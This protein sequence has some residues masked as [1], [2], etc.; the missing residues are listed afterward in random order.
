MGARPLATLAVGRA[1][2]TALD[3]AIGVVIEMLIY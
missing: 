3:P 2:S 1:F